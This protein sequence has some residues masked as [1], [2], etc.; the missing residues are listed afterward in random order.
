MSSSSLGAPPLALVALFGV[1]LFYLYM[2]TY[3]HFEEELEN[4][5]ITFNIV[6]FFIPAFLLFLMQCSYKTGEK[7]F[8]LRIPRPDHGAI[9][10]AGGSPCGMAVLLALLLV[11]IS[12]HSS[13][14]SRWFRPLWYSHYY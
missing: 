7:W 14:G 11:M 12:Y 3:F 6:L 2:S 10:R 9:H 8:L 1:V 4:A 13:V 5:M